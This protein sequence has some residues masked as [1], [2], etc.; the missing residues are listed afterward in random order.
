MRSSNLLLPCA[1]V[2]TKAVAIGQ[3]ASLT[4][5]ATTGGLRLSGGG[6]TPTIMIDSNDWLG[7]SRAGHDLAN[8]FEL[9]TGSK[10][11]VVTNSSSLSNSEP[12][13][14][15]GTIGKSALIDEL[16]SAKKIDVSAIDGKWES[17]ASQLIE[18][19]K[20]LVLAGSD[21]R[22]T[23]FAIYDISEQIGVS[24]WYWWADVP[25][26]KKTD[27]YALPTLKN[28]GPPSVKYRGIFL[29]DEQPALTDWVKENYG[30]YDSRF[31]AKIFEL[32]LRLRANYL[33][34][35]MW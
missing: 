31:Y 9:V 23:I 2:V 4:F 11:T 19:P 30:K 34:P 22:G 12:L 3:R 29:N 5:T 21:K 13:I 14:I 27:I 6:F 25:P 18:D 1:F 10:G 24:P 8:D 32:L 28:Q 26:K 17:F 7:V 15:A 20:A 33:W 16:I 35:A